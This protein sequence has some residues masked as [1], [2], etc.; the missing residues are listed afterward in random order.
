M[1]VY[2]VNIVFYLFPMRS[3][4]FIRALIFMTFLT[5][6]GQSV[7]AVGEGNRIDMAVSPIRDEFTVTPGTPINRTVQYNNNSDT[8]YVIYMSV[9]DCQPS[10]N[11]GTPICST[12]TGS[13][14]NPEFSSTW[15][16]L[17]D[18]NF[19][20]PPHGS[21]IVSYTVTVPSGAAPG[22]H[23]GAIF[24]NNPDSGTGNLNSVGMIRRIGMLY[25]MN[26]PGNIIVNPDVGDILV[27]GPGGIGNNP[28]TPMEHGWI[29]DSPLLQSA[30]DFVKNLAKDW[31][32]LWGTI[33]DDLNP[34]WSKPTLSDEPFSV[35]LK[36]PVRNDGNIHIRPTGKVY[37]YDE[38]GVQLKQ[39]GKESVVNENGVFI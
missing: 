17:S 22:G 33:A 28:L 37:L 38:N 21:K 7:S 6:G 16:H 19:T 20:V 35:T 1:S 15:I 31:I 9:E 34:F 25:L 18:T 11:Y 13:G 24:F 30:P 3:S 4:S 2:I 29:I 5:L 27:D 8:P 32:P 36:I 39:I 12:P 10:G 23:Y 14:V 26:I